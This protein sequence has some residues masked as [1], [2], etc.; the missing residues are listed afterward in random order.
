MMQLCSLNHNMLAML[1]M[2]LGWWSVSATTARVAHMGSPLEPSLR[3]I[4]LSSQQ[5]MTSMSYTDAAEAGHSMNDT[6]MSILNHDAWSA[7]SENENNDPPDVR[8]ERGPSPTSGSGQSGNHRIGATAT[9]NN[10]HTKTQSSAQKILS[11]AG[12]S[13][14]RILTERKETKR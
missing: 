4:S 11:C 3:R 12:K 5:L 1:A 8:V 7:D 13:F 14:L 6:P 2:L 9:A 10:S